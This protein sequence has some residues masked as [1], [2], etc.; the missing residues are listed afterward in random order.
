MPAPRKIA[1][2]LM[3]A[4]V[5]YSSDES[6]EWASAML[7]ELDFIEGDWEALFWALGCTTAIFRHSSRSLWAWFGRQLGFKEEGMGNFQKWTVGV[8]SGIG[9]TILA[10]ALLMTV[11]HLSDYF[12]NFA[13]W[14]PKIVIG[15]S[16]LA[17][18]LFVGAVIALWRKRRPMAAGILFTAILLGTHFA[19]YISTHHL[20][21]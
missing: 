20:G 6:R 14:M 7:Q 11:V 12:F 5:R 17:E 2:R 18:V 1:I 8:L 16:A 13:G 3:S 9:L 21:R 15:M 4:V 10:T 19:M